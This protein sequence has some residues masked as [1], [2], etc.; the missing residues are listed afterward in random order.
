MG[1]EGL[2][3]GAVWEVWY[4]D[5]F[6]RET[7][8]QVEVTGQLLVEGLVELWARHLFGTVQKDGKKGFCRFNLW[9]IPEGKSIEVVGDW[10]GQVRLR[11]WVYPLK[12]QT[13]RSVG[14][15]DRVLLE[16]VAV[17]HWQYIQRGETSAEILAVAGT[18]KRREDFENWLLQ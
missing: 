12:R 17:K 16:K 18:S 7:P 6:D 14:T 13:N 9:W 10:E 11:K 1:A 4:Q 2:E 8:R 5:M 15:Q 3:P